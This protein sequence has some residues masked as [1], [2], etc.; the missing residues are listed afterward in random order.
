MLL[1]TIGAIVGC[2][3]TSVG[4][5][6]ATT[7][8]HTSGILELLVSI[9]DLPSVQTTNAPV[10]TVK[11]NDTTRLT[12]GSYDNKTTLNASII[13]S[14]FSVDDIILEIIDSTVT[15]IVDGVTLAG[16]LVVA[17]GL[18]GIRRPDG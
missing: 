3:V 12:K 11:F 10:I 8:T 4:H 1:I 13:G 7:L 6:T 9:F 2:D 16:T 5:V 15:G 17:V 18:H 14:E